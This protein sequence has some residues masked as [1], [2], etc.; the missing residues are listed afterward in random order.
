M[1]WCPSHKLFPGSHSR[2]LLETTD[3]A[4]Q[5]FPSLSTSSAPSEFLL[6]EDRAVFTAVPLTVPPYKTGCRRQGQ[7]ED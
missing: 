6:D 4:K 2:L 1:H 7:V 5:T 3:G